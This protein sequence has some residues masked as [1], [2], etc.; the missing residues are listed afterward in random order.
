MPQAHMFYFKVVGSSSVS[1]L[2]NRLQGDVM[3]R[4]FRS[5]NHK[6]PE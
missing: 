1:V 4:D 2:E 6:N 5:S 3:G